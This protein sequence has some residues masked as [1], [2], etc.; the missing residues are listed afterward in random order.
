MGTALELRVR[1]DTVSSAR[2]AEARILAEIDR[3]SA[4]FSGYDPASEFS[5]WQADV[6]GPVKVSPE[7]WEVLQASDRWRSRSAGT[8]DPRV[9]ALT[10]LWSQ[11]ARR[12]RLPTDAEL[13]AAQALMS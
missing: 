9:E 12:D 1:A 6:S 4:I 13:A 8:F 10:R 5:R 11:C 2:W 3:L 7:L